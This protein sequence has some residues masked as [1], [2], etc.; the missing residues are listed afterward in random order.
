MKTFPAIILA[1]AMTA[2]G[3][4]QDW[5]QRN[6]WGGDFYRAQQRQAQQ[7]EC[8]RQAQVA[9]YREGARRAAYEEEILQEQWERNQEWNAL[10]QEIADEAE[11][12]R[13]EMQ[14]EIEALREELEA[15]Q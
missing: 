12:V 5:N 13:E 15:A 1:A 8:V 9:R 7:Q 6:Q 2:P 11:A 10:R 14:D 4:S 3:Y